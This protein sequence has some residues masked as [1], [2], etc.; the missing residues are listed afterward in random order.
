MDVSSVWF[1]TQ[2]DSRQ[3]AALLLGKRGARS[4]L[5]LITPLTFPHGPSTRQLGCAVL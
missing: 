5:V 1:Q 4:Y 2:S 3:T